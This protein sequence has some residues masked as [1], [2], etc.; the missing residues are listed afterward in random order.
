MIKGTRLTE[1]T[2]KKFFRVPFRFLHTTCACHKRQI[3]F[4][5]W[6]S[7][8]R[9]IIIIKSIIVK[10]FYFIYNIEQTQY[11]GGV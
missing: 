11:Y 2:W 8:Y 9:Q 1:A 3:R 10:F 5:I 4:E 7:L 6:F